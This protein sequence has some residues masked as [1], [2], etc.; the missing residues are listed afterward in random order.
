MVY[1]VLYKTLIG[2]KSL[3]IRS[4]VIDGFIRVYDGT[5]YLVL[6]GRKKYDVIYD[7]IRHLLGLKNDITHVFSQNYAKIKVGSD[8]D[9]PLEEICTLRNVI[10]LIKSVLNKDQNRCC[11]N[12]FL[13][14]CSN[15][16]AEKVAA[17]VFDSIMMLRF[18]KI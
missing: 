3:C 6:F 14:K 13:G 2:P 4:D 12:K 11:Y 15:Q 9:L 8:N 7:R 17:K 18:D 5:K 16:F 10:I 1:D